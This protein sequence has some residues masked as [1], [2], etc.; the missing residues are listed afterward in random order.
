MPLDKRGIAILSG[1]SLGL[2][3]YA[4]FAYRLPRLARELHLSWSQLQDQIGTDTP[5]MLLARKVREVMPQVKTAYPHARVE[6]TRHGIAMK[7]SSP[8]VPKRQVQGFRL[9][10]SRNKSQFGLQQSASRLELEHGSGS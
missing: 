6:I 5:R 2:D 9:V 4:L 8:A 3:L 7:Q 10:D 1:N